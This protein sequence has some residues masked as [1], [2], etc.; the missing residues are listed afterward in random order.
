[1]IQYVL[2]FNQKFGLPLGDVDVLMEDTH[3][4]EYRIKF[5]Q[6]ELDELREALEQRDKVKMFDALLDMAYVIYGTALFAGVSVEQWHVGFMAVHQA[7]MAK[8]RVAKPEESKRRS[9]FDVRKPEGWTPP[10]EILKE[11]LEWQK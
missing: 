10:E 5:L 2:E 8:V 3:A 1:M 4:Q 7:N 11:I 6:E 9:A